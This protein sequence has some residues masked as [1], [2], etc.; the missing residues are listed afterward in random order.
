[1]SGSTSHPKHDFE[2]IRS[3]NPTSKFYVHD[4]KHT[5]RKIIVLT[6]SPNWSETFGRKGATPIAGCPTRPTHGDVCTTSRSVPV[7]LVAR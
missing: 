7:F 5:Y 1:M 4:L 3:R 2:D 6:D